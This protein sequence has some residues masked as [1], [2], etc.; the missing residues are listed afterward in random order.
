MAETSAE[1]GSHP[2]SGGIDVRYDELDLLLAPYRQTPDGARRLL[3]EVRF[4]AGD[5]YRPDGVDDW[6]RWSPSR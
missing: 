4:D 6:F 1:P 3:G 5:R 2:G